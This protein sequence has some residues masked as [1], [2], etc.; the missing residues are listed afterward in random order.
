MALCMD[1]YI[2]IIS[3]HFIMV[4]GLLSQR[5]LAQ[6]ILWDLEISV[7]TFETSKSTAGSL[8]QK[9]TCSTSLLESHLKVIHERQ[10]ESL[11][12]EFF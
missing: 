1:I 7:F 3:A 5:L 10:L 11:V 12:N 9:S 8:A 2:I 6:Q 4:L